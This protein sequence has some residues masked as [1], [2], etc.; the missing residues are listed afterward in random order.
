MTILII[1]LSAA[2]ATLGTIY[3]LRIAKFK[4]D[5]WIAYF[6]ATIIGS[7]GFLF[8][9]DAIS[10][11]QIILIVLSCLHDIVLACTG[12]FIFYTKGVNVKTINN[13]KQLME[14]VPFIVIVAIAFIVWQSIYLNFFMNIGF[15]SYIYPN[16][17]SVIAF[18]GTALLIRGYVLGFLLSAI[19]EL[20]IILQFSFGGNIV[21]Y[22]I[23]ALHIV[24]SIVFAM[25]WLNTRKVS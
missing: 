14:I 25:A 2:C 16:I 15:T 12:I 9:S 3:A 4:A 24:N 20:S 8:Y 5:A 13:Q 7:C 11:H 18:V 21:S 1:L 6:L 22:Y 17:F 19:F 23:I 10:L